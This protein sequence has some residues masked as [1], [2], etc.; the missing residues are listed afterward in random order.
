MAKCDLQTHPASDEPR[1]RDPCSAA[2]QF[3]ICQIGDGFFVVAC[4]LDDGQPQEAGPAAPAPTKM[5]V[6]HVEESSGAVQWRE[7]QNVTSRKELV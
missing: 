4:H 1:G 3:E 5:D 2:Q 6:Q 7:P